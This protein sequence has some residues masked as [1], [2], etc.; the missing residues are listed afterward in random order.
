MIDFF[1]LGS[2]IPVI[3]VPG[4]DGA[5][6]VSNG[7]GTLPSARGGGGGKKGGLPLPSLETLSLSDT[8]NPTGLEPQFIRRDPY[9]WAEGDYDLIVEEP[10][11]SLDALTNRIQ[12]DEERRRKI[13]ERDPPGS[14]VSPSE[15][16]GF[17]S[18]S[19]PDEKKSRITM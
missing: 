8:N 16:V 6:L 11:F 5:G 9:G 13:R 19:R 17:G 2:S 1:N 15:G 14:P 3:L 7:G 18:K 4:P 10:R 12:Q